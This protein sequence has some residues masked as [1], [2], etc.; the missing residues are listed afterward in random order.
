MF[1]VCVCVC[2]HAPAVSSPCE[3][4]EHTKKHILEKALQAIPSCVG[5]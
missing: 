5:A 3:E 2:L 4:K 1:G